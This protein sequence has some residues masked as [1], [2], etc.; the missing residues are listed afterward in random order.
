MLPSL[1]SLL[2]A[3]ARN[4]VI[5]EE[6]EQNNAKEKNKEVLQSTFSTLP[7]NNILRI[8]IRFSI[9]F[10]FVPQ[11][12]YLVIHDGFH[13]ETRS[14]DPMSSDVDGEDHID[15]IFRNMAACVVFETCIGFVPHADQKSSIKLV[16]RADV[17]IKCFIDSL[18][19]RM[20]WVARAGREPYVLKN[21]YSA[22]L[23]GATAT[24]QAECLTC[25]RVKL[26]TEGGAFFQL[27]TELKL[28]YATDLDDM[29]Q[30][31]ERPYT[32]AV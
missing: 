11:K 12:C 2:D 29:L 19:R 22:L 5:E 17:W 1:S 7:K 21:K 3:S 20:K 26:K 28:Y 31:N 10:S 30:S 8:P 15:S 6:Q 4:R 9:N 25:V 23:A 14:N 13:Y 18:Q 32:P 27:E 24:L 16:V